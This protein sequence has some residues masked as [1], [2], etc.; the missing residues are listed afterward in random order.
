MAANPQ[1]VVGSGQ[2]SNPHVNAHII[3]GA[4]ISIKTSFAKFDF[5]LK[6]VKVNSGSSFIHTL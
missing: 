5:V 1:S 2:I 6:W 4:T 3:S